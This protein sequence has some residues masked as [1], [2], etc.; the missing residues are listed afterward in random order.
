[1]LLLDPHDPQEL[2]FALHK[3][4]RL[5]GLTLGEICDRLKDDY[6]VELTVSGLN[7]V[8]NRGTIRLQRALQILAI[9]GVS[10]V[11]IKGADSKRTGNN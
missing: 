9:C 10:Q 8:I 6:G 4:V 2:A 11:E 3:A 5:S 1:M 7:H